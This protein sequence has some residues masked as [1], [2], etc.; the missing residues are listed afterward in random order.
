M[1]GQPVSRV[2]G[3]LKVTGR[4]KYAGE[5]WPE[6]LDRPL[7]GY[8]VGSAIGSGRVAAIDAS[9]AESAPGL[10]LLMTHLN[11]PPQ[12][13]PDLSLMAQYGRAFPVLA[14]PE[15][16]H[17][18]EPVALVVADTFEQARAA[19]YLVNVVYNPSPGAFDLSAGLTSAYAPKAVNA[20]IATDS[21]LGDFDASFA[22]AAVRVDEV[23]ATPYQFAQPMEPHACLAWWDGDD[24]HARISSQVVGYACKAIAA[25]LNIDPARVHVT[26][27]FVGGGFGS[28]LGI[29]AETILAVLAAREL[30]QP[31][32]I[33]LT[34]DQIFQL[35]GVRPAS[36]QQIRL[37]ADRTG[38]LVAIGHE[39]TTFTS[40]VS[41]WCEQTAACTRSLYAA[42]NRRTRHRLTKLNL[43]RGED[44]RAP[45]EGPGLLAIESAMDE[46]AHALDID[47]VELRLINEPKVDPERNIPFSERRLVDCLREG[48]KRFGWDRRKARPSSV[49]D[50]SWLVGMGMAAGIRF[51]AQAPMKAKVSMGPDGVVVVKSDMTD[52]GTG[53]YTIAAQVAAET[54][55]IPLERI[56]VE[57]GNSD[58]P[59]SAGSGASWGAANTSVAVERACT[60]LKE[61]LDASSGIPPESIEAEGASAEAWFSP[62]TTPYSIHCYAAYFAEVGVDGDTGEI[63][64]RRMLGVFSAGRI[65]NPKTARSQL[66]GG[67]TLGIAYALHEE[68]VVDLRS[69]AF[70]N[71]DLAQYLV[72]VNADIPAIEAVLLD[73]FDDKAN[74]LG[75]KGVGELGVCGSG[76]A[77]ANAVF[78]ATGV[79]VREFPITIEKLLPG[80]GP[81]A[82]AERSRRVELRGATFR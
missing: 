71:R 7:Y 8:I 53:T 5:Q 29:H 39:V 56:R 15:I 43:F 80:L 22:G 11:A 1:I 60:A 76:A 2:D 16:L 52:I 45:G 74:D 14:S 25:T 32:K 31:V 36:H 61:R 73:G 37:A 68:G 12:G 17:F 9:R 26:S 70:A 72:P 62:M 18:G 75:V 81:P 47:P 66:I 34:R 41:E 48:A 65:L 40:P 55:G 27:P 82:I 6:D 64:L 46:L 63:R 42:P 38:R 35:V 50:D 24:V 19:A 13:T 79:R 23:Y 69:G 4:A 78:N 77:V 67:M 57:L 51:S 58:D 30:R 59:A 3:P 33:H 21:E 54:L 10:R 28:K 20:G 44:V 49:R